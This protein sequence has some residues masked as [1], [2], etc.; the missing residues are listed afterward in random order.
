M[1]R[2]LFSNREMPTAFRES[3][4]IGE[5]TAHLGKKPVHLVG[6]PEEVREAKEQLEKEYM[7]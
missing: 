1:S 3:D 7:A 2:S 4:A 5:E 6:P